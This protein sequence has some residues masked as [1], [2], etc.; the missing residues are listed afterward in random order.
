MSYAATHV[1]LMFQGFLEFNFQDTRL[2]YSITA[3][4]IEFKLVRL[5]SLPALPAAADGVAPGGAT[6]GAWARGWSFLFGSEEDHVWYQ[7][8]GILY[9]EGPQ[10]YRGAREEV[11]P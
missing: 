7:G 11:G 4:Y 3:N 6:C 9:C 2:G 8:N 5:P 10:E 1:Q